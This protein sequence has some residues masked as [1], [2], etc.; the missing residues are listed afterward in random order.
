MD[1]LETADNE[2]GDNA[3]GAVDPVDSGLF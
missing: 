2:D 3:P 1:V